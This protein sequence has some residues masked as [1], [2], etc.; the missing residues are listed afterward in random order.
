MA[1]V[2]IKRGNIEVT[3][4][5]V[6]EA[7]K[8]ILALE[9]KAQR[10]SN[11]TSQAHHA[12]AT[13]ARPNPPRPPSPLQDA[14]RKALS[15]GPQTSRQLIEAME[16]AGYKF[17][18]QDKVVAVNGALLGL[19]KRGEARFTGTGADGIQKLWVKGARH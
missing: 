19:E 10:S 16:G 3:L 15:N 7:A 5:S 2:T 4:D 14:V 17:T 1:K 18:A 13:A 12:P 9:H 11:T 6:D 8:L